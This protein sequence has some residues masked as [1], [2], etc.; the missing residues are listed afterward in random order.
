MSESRHIDDLLLGWRD[1]A[2][3]PEEYEQLVALLQT[4]TGRRALVEEFTFAA[5]ARESAALQPHEADERLI[6]VN[7]QELES[8]LTS[9][10]NRVDA[11]TQ[12]HAADKGSAS[13]PATPGTVRERSIYISFRQS[14]RGFAAAAAILL[15]SAAAVWRFGFSDD[16][17][18]AVVIAP[19]SQPVAVAKVISMAGALEVLSPDGKA[20]SVIAGDSVLAGQ[21]LRTLG[22]DS[23]AAVDFDDATRLELAVDTTI[24]FAADAG[25]HVYLAGG[26]VR[27]D[28]PMR[29]G[30]V[31]LVVSSSQA[32]I[33]GRGTRFSV[34]SAAS[35][36]TRIDLESGNAQLVR[37]SD[38]RTVEV[39]AGS[40]AIARADSEPVVVQRVPRF[41]AQPRVVFDTKWALGV[42]ADPKGGKIYA[43]TS[44]G[45]Q[46][47]DELA[48]HNYQLI[49]D[50]VGEVGA[51]SFAEGGRIVAMA[52]SRDGRIH[53][54]DYQSQRPRAVIDTHLPVSRIITAAYDGSWV[55]VVDQ[56]TENLFRVFDAVGGAEG[57]ERFAIKIDEIRGIRA[58]AAS[59]LGNRLAIASN[60]D[61]RIGIHRLY[62][63]NPLT[64]QS[65]GALAGHAKGVRSIA[66]S[67]D[68]RT[69][70]SA[71][72]D[73]TLRLWDVAT[74]SL[75]LHIDGYEQSLN[76]LTFSSDGRMV[77]GGGN[78]GRIWVWDTQTGELG[79]VVSA[80]FRAVKSIALTPDSRH[81][82]VSGFD[83]QLMVF[84][85]PTVARTSRP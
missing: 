22:A 82:V 42:F 48:R 80:G 67:P 9:R 28:V 43:A 51:S 53:L 72:D 76:C 35:Q 83:T 74:R 27:V 33:R 70:A 61:K 57:I 39:S 78:D 60:G 75:R 14:A 7:A 10:A 2:L 52:A 44:R 81:L 30:G 62:L 73:G 32:E 21:T 71:A 3:T 56:K 66:F 12:P 29:P 58:M 11:A 65:I 55:A 19:T 68:G 50:N 79:M 41:V 59:P 47:W 38:G 40:Y 36:A 6:A 25:K 1:D 5:V 26:V 84:E 4:P 69:L 46:S 23:Y 63:Y 15:L 37:Q 85:L 64:G 16:E 20:R 54:W 13:Q 49:Y 77:A 45:I 34:S 18:P 24:R 8:L 31:P 17:P